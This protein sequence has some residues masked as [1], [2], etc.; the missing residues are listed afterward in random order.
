MNRYRFYEES[1]TERIFRNKSRKLSKD[2][3]EQI[4]DYREIL[5]FYC[6]YY[7]VLMSILLKGGKE[8]LDKRIWMIHKARIETWLSKAIYFVKKIDISTAKTPPNDAD[9][10]KDRFCIITNEEKIVQRIDKVLSAAT[11]TTSTPTDEN[12][13]RILAHAT[14]VLIVFLSKLE[15]SILNILEAIIMELLQQITETVNEQIKAKG[16]KNL[17]VC[18]RDISPSEIA[19][20]TKRKLINI[21]KL[22]QQIM[23]QILIKYRDIVNN[24]KDQLQEK[25]FKETFIHKWNYDSLLNTFNEIRAELKKHQK[26]RDGDVIMSD[27]QEMDESKEDEIKHLK[28][29][30]QKQ[31]QQIDQ[32]N[33]K[34]KREQEKQRVSDHLQQVLKATNNITPATTNANIYS[35]IFQQQQAQAQQQIEQLQN[36]NI[37]LN[38]R[39]DDDILEWVKEKID[40]QRTDR[41]TGAINNMTS[42]IS[43]VMSSNAVSTE[44][45]IKIIQCGMYRTNIITFIFYITVQGRGIP[46]S[47]HLS[48]KT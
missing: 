30:I 1:G 10:N 13:A 34:K 8:A 42:K 33:E 32:Y 25:E 19:T 16:N 17:K 9:I 35:Q 5:L 7:F 28:E 6:Y 15:P 23:E 41:V 20:P 18:I 3:C 22:F 36:T 37:N 27:K 21:N 14:E 2:H 38:V 24:N 11:K 43:R 40:I 46:T 26:V 12:R 45:I 48:I 31:Q 39:D 4:R 29:M 44:N 47:L